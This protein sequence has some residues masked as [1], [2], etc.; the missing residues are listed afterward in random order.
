M[1][2]I[3]RFHLNV[4]LDGFAIEQPWL[5]AFGFAKYLPLRSPIRFRPQAAFSSIEIILILVFFL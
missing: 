1:A 3:A 2:K 5:S 4:W